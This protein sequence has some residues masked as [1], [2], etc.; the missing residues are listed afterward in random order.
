MFQEKNIV[1]IDKKMEKVKNTIDNI[2]KFLIDNF[3]H[4]IIII[5]PTKQKIR[6]FFI[7]RSYFS[8]I[9]IEILKIPNI[10]MIIKKIIGKSIKRSK[11]LFLFKGE[12]LTIFNYTF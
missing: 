11:L 5:S 9:L 3:E 8:S 7:R 6:C 4:E 1:D 2:I 10:P 12:I